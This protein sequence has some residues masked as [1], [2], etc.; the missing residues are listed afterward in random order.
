MWR[1]SFTVAMRR[2]SFPDTCGVIPA[3]ARI[4]DACTSVAGG[5]RFLGVTIENDVRRKG[6][7]L[8]A[9]LPILA[10]LCRRLR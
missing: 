7:V 6:M 3:E 9:A 4:Q 5:P 8:S 2:S 1:F 10:A